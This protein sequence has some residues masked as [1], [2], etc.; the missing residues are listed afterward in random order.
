[1][2]RLKTDQDELRGEAGNDLEFWNSGGRPRIG[3]RRKEG[4]PFGLEAESAGFRESVDWMRQ[5]FDRLVS[6]IH[7]RL[8][9]LLRSKG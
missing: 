7:P 1:M 8:Q 2:S 3:F 6:T 5:K 4:L 9:R